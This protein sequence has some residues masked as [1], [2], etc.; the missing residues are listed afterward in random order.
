MF[1]IESNC[2]FCFFF[3]P[4]FIIKSLFFY[5]NFKIPSSHT[6]IMYSACTYKLPQCHCYSSHCIYFAN[7]SNRSLYHGKKTTIA[8]PVLGKAIQKIKRQKKQ[9]HFSFRNS[10]L[11]DEPGKFFERIA[12]VCIIKNIL[13]DER[14]HFMRFVLY[15]YSFG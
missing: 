10:L 3:F 14:L 2:F 15:M 7:C 6:L 13:H 1:V 9:H 11:Q 12:L 4:N 5:T 8:G